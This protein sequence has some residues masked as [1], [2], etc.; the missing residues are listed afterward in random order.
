M[1]LSEPGFDCDWGDW[2]E[3]GATDPNPENISDSVLA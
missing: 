3:L 1:S 2:W